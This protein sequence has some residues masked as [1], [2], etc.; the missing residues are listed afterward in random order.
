MVKEVATISMHAT[1]ILW[2]RSEDGILVL[3]G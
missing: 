1:R 2:A 3:G